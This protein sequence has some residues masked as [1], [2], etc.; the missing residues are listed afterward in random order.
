[1]ARPRSEDRKNAIMAAATR[2][3][4]AQGLA[5]PT[6]LIAM[7]AGISNGSLFTYFETKADLLNALY[8]DLKTEMAS[9]ALCDLS[10]AKDV[11]DQMA[12][13][14]KGWLRW[15]TAA[16]DKRRTL[17]Q[18]A[19]SDEITNTSRD[20]GRSAMGGAAEIL[21]RSRANGPMQAVPLG[22]VAGLMNAVAD[23]T[24]EFILQD[25]AN[26]DAHSRAGFE[27]LWRMIA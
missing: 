27:A 4:A 26:Y 6:S 22:L 25:P 13:M 17:A 8:V 21:E 9:A 23:A 15:A 10:P 20:I 5:A 7:E 16:P 12:S 3:I 14:W 19:V 2:V 11:R 18:L 1:M 24:V